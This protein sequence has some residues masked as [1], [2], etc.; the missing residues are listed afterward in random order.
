MFSIRD[1]W[2]LTPLDSLLGGGPG[3]KFILGLLTQLKEGV[4][5]LEDPKTNV[6]LDITD[7]TFSTG[8]FVEVFINISDIF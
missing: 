7:A 6:P 3:K 8:L 1:G 4:Y 2:K 5:Y